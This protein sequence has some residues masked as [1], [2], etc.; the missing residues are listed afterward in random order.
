MNLQWHD[1]FLLLIPGVLAYFNNPN[2]PK[3][4]K[5]SIA[6]AVCFMAAFLEVSFAGQCDLQN[7]GPTLGK[8]FALVMGSYGGFWK[9]TGLGDKIENNYGT[10]Q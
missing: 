8:V 6:F 3:A 10:G 2:W 4:L 5:F 7:F 1:M 9:P